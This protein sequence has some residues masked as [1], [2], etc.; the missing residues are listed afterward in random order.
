MTSTTSTTSTTSAARVPAVRVTGV[1]GALVRAF[2]RRMLGDVPESLGVMW[3]HKTLLKD[4]MSIGRRSE[5]W[6][7]LDKNLGTFAVMAAAATVGCGA[8]LD[9]NY[10][11]AHHR[12]LDEEKAREVPRWRESAVFS[13]V[14]RHVLEY[15]EAMTTTPPSVTDEMSAVLLDELGPAGLLELSARV[16]V[17]NM[18]ARTNVALGIRSQEFAASCGLAPLARPTTGAQDGAGDRLVA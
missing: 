17:M 18:N 13:P 11:L 16:G 15:A 4:F 7:H 9:L 10:F 14:E 8:C 12:G 2:S 6:G 5:R 3:H 1:Y